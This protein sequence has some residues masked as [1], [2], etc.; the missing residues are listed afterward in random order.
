MEYAYNLTAP[1]A[2]PLVRKYQIIDTL[3]YVG[4]PLLAPGANEAGLDLGT[5]T[6]AADFVGIN[7]DTATYVT[8]QQTDGTSA[9]R[10]V[11]VIINPDAVYRIKLSGGATE[12]TALTLYDVTTAS[13]DGLTVTTGDS[14]TSPEFD[15]GVVWGYDGANA[16]QQRKITSTSSTAATVTVAFDYDTVVGDNFMR[17]P[18]W[19]I[20]TTTVQFTTNLYQADASIAVATG[21]AFRVVDMVLR[22]IGHNGRQNSFA[23]I[24]SSDHVLSQTT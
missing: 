8:A 15:E 12:N 14:W 4:V 18:Y 1:N 6:G 9:E 19:Y 10:K 22:D 11:S 16:G 23:D 5:T 24:W 7:L 3:S 17:A 2:T 20:G 21:A 13:T